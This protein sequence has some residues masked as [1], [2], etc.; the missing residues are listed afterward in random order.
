LCSVA[1]GEAPSIDAAKRHSGCRLEGRRTVA[2]LL[3]AP[4]RGQSEASAVASVEQRPK[5]ALHAND[6]GHLDVDQQTQVEIE[7]R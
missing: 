5:S 4:S 7:S 1:R 3:P 2:L 6:F